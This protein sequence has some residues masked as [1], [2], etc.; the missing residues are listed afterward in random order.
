[1][2][3]ETFPSKLQPLDDSK[4]FEWPDR[5]DN[6][7]HCIV[8]IW[9]ESSIWLSPCVDVH[10]CSACICLADRTVDIV[11]DWGAKRPMSAP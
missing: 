5:N 3:E 2:R 8:R 4:P 6:Y 1:M 10:D 11:E 7:I 9:C